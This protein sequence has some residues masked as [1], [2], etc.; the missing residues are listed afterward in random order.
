MMAEGKKLKWREAFKAQGKTALWFI[1]TAFF[2]VTMALLYVHLIVWPQ[3]FKEGQVVPYTVFSP[4]TFK[5]QDSGKL[6]QFTGSA[7]EVENSWIIDS[8]IK[9]QA[10]EQLA[11]FQTDFVALRV[12]ASGASLEDPDVR[13]DF[14][15]LSLTHGLSPK[16]L[17]AFL[18]YTDDHLD[19]IFSAAE[20]ALDQTMSGRV[21]AET[22]TALKEGGSPIL[23]EN[24]ED[25]FI[26]FLQPN[27]NAYEPPEISKEFR[28]LATT[29]IDRGSVIVAKGQTID[30]Q[31]AE[32][33]EQLGPHQEMQRI[34]R[35]CGMGLLLLTML[36]VWFLFIHRFRS[37]Q[38]QNAGAYAQFALVFEAFLVF[39]LLIGRFPANYFFYGVTFAV[40]ALATVLVLIYDSVLALY[41]ALGLGLILSVGLHF[42]ADLMMYTLCGAMLPVAVLGPSSS[43]RAQVFF[44]LGAGI[45]NLAL[46]G[47][48]SLINAQPV[49]WA[50]YVVGFLAG[51]LGAVIALGLLPVM[52]YCS[53]QLTPGKLNDLANQEN[54][55][56][57]KLKREAIGTFTHSVLVADLAEEACRAVNAEWLKAKVGALYHDIGKLK[58][59][60]FFAENIHDLSKNPHEPL[61]PETSAR[62]LKDHVVDGMAMAK[63]ERLPRE[64]HRFIEEHHGTYLVKYFYYQAAEAHERNPEDC[65]RPDPE[66]FCYGGPIPQ[67]RESGIVMLADITEAVTRSKV[68]ASGEEIVN[69][70]NAVVADKLEEGQLVDSGLT[71][72][73]LDEVKR[74]FIRV[75]AAQRHQRVSYPGQGPAPMQ[76]HWVERER[77]PISS[78]RG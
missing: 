75:L 61:P 77:P 38:A 68:A 23:L 11:Q 39:G 50:A 3:E 12:K 8:S 13:P 60:G 36:A 30:R 31:A 70:I 24:P 62:I 26:Y 9:E 10:L 29:W 22:I 33:L 72:G 49:H 64:L 48:V 67:S 73:D 51:F 56:L 76:F 55:L 66:A 53:T 18:V 28:E 35:F 41:M 4:I 1:A 21:S 40:V 15:E 71:V 54:E 63:A 19:Q 43:R 59:P 47:V 44:A 2:V 16:I 5:Y 74:A 7:A 17:P 42:Q 46:A 6:E 57:R 34:Y 37:E 69:I 14:M 20:T 58:R 78:K 65:P 52:E 25:I 45:A 27:I 32:Q